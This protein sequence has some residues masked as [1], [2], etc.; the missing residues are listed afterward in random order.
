MTGMQPFGSDDDGLARRLREIDP[1]RGVAPLPEHRIEEI[2]TH[3][4]TDGPS[5]D[6]QPI[7]PR[8]VQARRRGIVAAITTAAA[9]TAVV[10]AVIVARPAGGDTLA[11]SAPDPGVSTAC[12]PLAA[13]FIADTDVAFEGRVTGIDGSTVRLEVLHQYTGEPASTVTIPQGTEDLIELT[14]GRFEL[15]GTYLISA[16]AG[17][18]TTCGQS[19]PS[20]PEL[21]S[22]YEA[23]FS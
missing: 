19:G 1:A 10:T 3:T 7:D 9:A 13:E 18:V 16:V 5:G 14:T 4:T 8:A 20:T 6:T 15:G 11:L 23:A 21:K 17:V 2:M 12:A 22:L